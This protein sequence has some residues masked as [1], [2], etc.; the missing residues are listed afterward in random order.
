MA[1]TLAL[2]RALE[3][4]VHGEALRFTA[5]QQLVA[6]IAAFATIADGRIARF[7]TYDCYEPFGSRS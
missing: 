5:G 6:H 4:G 2:P 7:E 3:R 1:A